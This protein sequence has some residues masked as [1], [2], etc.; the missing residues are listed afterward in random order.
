MFKNY[1]KE[2]LDMNQYLKA[3]KE[4]PNGQRYC[5]AFCQKYM[6]EEEFYDTRAN[7]KTCFNQILKARKM[8]D[9]NQLTAE[10]F[11]ENPS[12]V[13]RETVI[14]PVYRDCK[15]CKK[16]LTL[17]KFEAQRHECIECRK[18]KTKINHEAKFK[19]YL[20]AIE[21]AKKDI[22]ALT[23]VIRSMS[24]D[25]V[26]LAVTHFKIKHSHE[27]R[28]KD[29]LV[30]KLIDHFKSLLNSYIC[31][32]SCGL[33]LEKEFSVCDVC[34]L[35]PKTS[36]E[37]KLLEFEKNLEDT[38]ANLTS[39]T[40]DDS[41][42]Y[43]KKEVIMIAKKLKVKFYQT[44]DKPVIMEIIQKHLD[45]E[46][47]KEKEQILKD[48][49]GELN[50]NGIIIKSREDGFVDATSL[51]KAGGKQFNDWYRL[52][53]TKELIKALEQEEILIT[54][55][56]VIKNEDGI[57][58]FKS[59]DVCK[60]RYGGSWIHPD[61]A[62]Q[63][64]QWLS[65]T[66]ALQVSRWIRQLALTGTVTIG[67]EKTSNELLE[68]QKEHKKL[69]HKHRKLLQ[70]KNYHKF[71][72]GACFYIISNIDSKSITFKPGFEGVD[73]DVRM[74]QHRSSI[75]G[76][77]L[78]YL[79]YSNDAKLVEQAV[80]KRF[81]SKRVFANHEWVF[82]VDVNYIIKSTR[83]I[84]DILNIEYTEEDCIEDYNEQIITEFEK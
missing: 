65:P 76:C 77:K 3:M 15:G 16:E 67:K 26:K 23:K 18:K 82:D 5:N 75:A 29:I 78:E 60:G 66:F 83:T 12:L 61:L 43:T 25:V 14:I 24:A 34:K 81:E 79:I 17:E 62:V 47:E 1:V 57:T 32:G 20:P 63:L 21:E 64:A 30:T 55:Y 35:K 13:E 6:D 48:L 53:T 19:E 33:E 45:D 42:K 41:Y 44:Q 8:I 36:V 38:V 37:E 52:E 49:G 7:C 72:K 27:E 56:P 70:K 59:V 73:I 2:S 80:L 39:M 40:P 11:K 28:K 74:R 69:E 22:T 54:G 10:K 46:K 9:N 4:A 58:T 71:K 31:L 50:I 68:L 51:C 84:L